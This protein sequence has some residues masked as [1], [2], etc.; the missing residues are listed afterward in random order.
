M[1]GNNCLSIY[2]KLYMIFSDIV[3]YIQRNNYYTI[4]S[5]AVGSRFMFTFRLFKVKKFEEAKFLIHFY[6]KYI[7]NVYSIFYI[8]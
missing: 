3:I 5:D 7:L 2:G 4:G 6:R 8:T 1:R